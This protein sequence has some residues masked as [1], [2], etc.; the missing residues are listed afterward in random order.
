MQISEAG[1]IVQAFGVD[2]VNQLLDEGWVI[3]AV[4]TSTYGDSKEGKVLPCYTLGK[5]REKTG[6]GLY[7][8]KV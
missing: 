5:P 3:L 1:E 7:G 4:T 6:V 8:Q 2:R